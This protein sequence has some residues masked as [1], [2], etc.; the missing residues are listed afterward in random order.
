ME[1][2]SDVYD[3]EVLHNSNSSKDS[4]SESADETRELDELGGD[5]NGVIRPDYFSVDSHHMHAEAV[6]DGVA[7]EENS[8]GSNNPSWIYPGSQTLCPGSNSAEFRSDSGGVPSDLRILTDLDDKNGLAIG[9]NVGETVIVGEIEVAD[10]KS[11][12]CWSDSEETFNLHFRKELENLKEEEADENE[13]REI[14]EDESRDTGNISFESGGIDSFSTGFPLLEKNDEVSI[15]EL[16]EKIGKPELPAGDNAEDRSVLKPQGGDGHDH[17]KKKDPVIEELKS[18]QKEDKRVV[19]WKVSLELFKNCVFRV[20]PVWPFSAAAVVMG[21]V[22]LGRRLYKLKRKPQGLQVNVTADYKRV[23]QFTSRAAR[24][25]EAFSVVRQISVILPSLPAP[26][27]APM[28]G[29]EFEINECPCV[30]ELQ[31]HRNVSVWRV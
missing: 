25:N 7:N 12:K 30:F 19:W 3:W 16:S 28:A 27:V 14:N 22:I 18:G 1:G 20:S 10:S 31:S 4:S 11:V 13:F 8:F 5:S 9:E 15:A 24:L 21:L 2:S 17:G 23:S 6:P 26:V 29:G